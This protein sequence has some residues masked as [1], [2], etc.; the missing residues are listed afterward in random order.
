MV[1]EQKDKQLA[2]V[3]RERDNLAL[4]SEA[5]TEKLK[6]NNIDFKPSE[7]KSEA[8]PAASSEGSV[9]QKSGIIEQYKAKL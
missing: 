7:P 8:S 1:I 2:Q 9:A 3:E 5:M 4:N 6:A